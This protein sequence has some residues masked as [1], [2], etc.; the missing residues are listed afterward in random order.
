MR[1][2]IHGEIYS[3]NFSNLN[4]LVADW[5]SAYRF[6]FCRFQ[7]DKLSFNEVRN[8]TKI[9]YPSLNTR[10]ISDAVMQAQG[11]YS[12][13]KDKKIIFGG[14]KY[15]N[16]LIKNEI[17][18]DEWKFKRDNQIYA[19]GDKTKKGNPNIRLLNK[20]GNFYLRVTIGNRKF[21]EYKLFIPAKFEEE[22]FSLF[23]SDNPY[24]VRLLWKD[25]QHFRV[26]IDFEIET[27]QQIIDF[28]NGVIGIDINPDRVAISNVSYDGNLIKSFT[29]KNNRMFFAS[30]NKRNY[31]IGCTIKEIINYAINSHKGIVFEN[32]KFKKEFENQGR[33]FNRTKSNFVWKKLVIL[34][35]RKCIENGIQYKKVNPAFTSVIGKFKYQKMY[36]LSIHESASYV[37]GRQG[38]GFNEKL[39][40]Y[41]YPSKYVKELV[42]DLVGDKTKQIHSWALWRKLRDNYKA[43]LTGLQSRMSNL[44]E[45]DDNLCYVGENPTSKVV[46]PKLVEGCL[47]AN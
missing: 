24:N 31:E 42:F 30:T 28:S 44:K 15:W 38:L 39:S 21:D 26:V 11:L 17:C 33:R 20:N 12:R 19:R 27:P 3:S 14:R 13:V 7:K 8:Q 41:K 9:K 34:L 23:G 37:I 32:L 36:N 6:S 47:N 40:L 10:Q 18:N 4:Q 22:L 25:K 29:T 46:P 45:L 1:C 16:K 5:S 2:V 43:V 35:E